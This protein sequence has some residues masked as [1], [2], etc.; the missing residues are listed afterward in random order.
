MEEERITKFVDRNS[1][2][3]G[4]QIAK[5]HG[6]VILYDC[7]E[8]EITWEKTTVNGKLTV[9]RRAVDSIDVIA[10]V[11]DSDNP[12]EQVLLEVRDYRPKLHQ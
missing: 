7:P 8:C 9:R 4:S 2:P 1:L 6:S 11:L 5:E 3:P 10:D 12:P